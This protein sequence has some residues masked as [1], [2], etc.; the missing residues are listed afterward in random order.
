MERRETR[1]MEEAGEA[2]GDVGGS[3]GTRGRTVSG[4]GIVLINR[5]IG[6][7]RAKRARSRSDGELYPKAK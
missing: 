1:D 5:S 3:R 7:W 4:G 2:V 6:Q